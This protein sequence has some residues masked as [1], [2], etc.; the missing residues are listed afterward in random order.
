[1]EERPVLEYSVYD[2]N[3]KGNSLTSI[4]TY[5]G[6][7]CS[8]YAD[9]KSILHDAGLPESYRTHCKGWNLSEL[10][11]FPVVGP[12]S[13]KKGAL[14]DCLDQHGLSRALEWKQ[15]LSK[16]N[17]VVLRQKYRAG[18]KVENPKY[19][20]GSSRLENMSWQYDFSI[21]KEIIVSPKKLRVNFLLLNDSAKNMHYQFGWHPA[22]RMQPDWE[23]YVKDET[24]SFQEIAAISSKEGALKIS[25]VSDVMYV[26]KNGK[27]GFLVETKGFGNMM[28]W[29]PNQ[30]SEMLCIEPV[31]H[32]PLGEGLSK[33]YCHILPSKEL[34][35]FSV[36][37]ELL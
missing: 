4:L 33:S 11:M 2:D 7:L 26:H 24:Y 20:K 29:S 8:F 28:L 32:L 23:V 35:E 10:V 31:T 22:F 6:Q 36:K 1:M 17:W 34:V 16:N 3:S 27:E 37:I 9:G 15:H 21:T 14:D 18:E 12:V 13:Q 19:S 25:D 30:E 5:D